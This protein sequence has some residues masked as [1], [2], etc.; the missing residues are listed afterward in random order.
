MFRYNLIEK[1]KKTNKVRMIISTFLTFIKDLFCPLFDLCSCRIDWL[2]CLWLL[3]TELSFRLQSWLAH[4]WRGK[5][6]T[7]Q[8]IFVVSIFLTFSP[9]ILTRT[10]AVGS[11]R[12]WSW[13]CARRGKRARSYLKYNT[14]SKIR[15]QKRYVMAFF[16]KRLP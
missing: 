7:S 1:I 10:G 9:P 3:G 12:S 6:W 16:G 5:I 2:S 13:I 14:C 4:R 11:L 15:S 8:I